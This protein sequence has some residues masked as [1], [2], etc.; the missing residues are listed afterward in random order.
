MKVRIIFFMFKVI[1]ELKLQLLV[2]HD[3]HLMLTVV[4]VH[5]VACWLRKVLVNLF[6]DLPHST[7]KTLPNAHGPFIIVVLLDRI[8]ESEFFEAGLGLGKYLNMHMVISLSLL[9]I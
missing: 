4:H 8:Q 1:L 6:Y 9:N 7:I 3:H 5:D 2:L